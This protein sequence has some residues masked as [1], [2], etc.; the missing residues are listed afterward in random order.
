[1]A[2]TLMPRGHT[3]TIYTMESLTP[4]STVMVLVRL[5]Q[6]RRPLTYK[7]DESEGHSTLRESIKRLYSDVILQ[8]EQFF[9]Q[10]KDE[11]WDRESVDLDMQAS[12]PD[13]SVLRVVL[14]VCCKYL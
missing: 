14:E 12:V 8:G 2:Q 5:G 6:R 7:P 1:M 11:Q 13:R 4:S 9:L 3:S 10:I